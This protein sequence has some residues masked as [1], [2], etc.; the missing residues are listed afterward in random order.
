VAV[1]GVPRLEGLEELWDEAQYA[2]EYDLDAFLK[3]L[4]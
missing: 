3:K 2:E 1:P 4:Q